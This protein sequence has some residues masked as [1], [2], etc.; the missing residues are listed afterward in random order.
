MSLFVCICI[1]LLGCTHT[2]TH[3]EDAGDWGDWEWG[4][5]DG[6][7]GESNDCIQ[8]LDPLQGKCDRWFHFTCLH[9][10]YGFTR[11]YCDWMDP[12]K[13]FVCPVCVK[14]PEYIDMMDGYDSDENVL[15]GYEHTENIEVDVVEHEQ[16]EGMFQLCVVLICL[17]VLRV[18]AFGYWP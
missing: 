6:R 4:C 9:E 13:G 15:E 1:V 14:E 10:K 18:H 3:S 16:R 5:C 2:R 11:E 7:R 12:T 8:C 17:Y